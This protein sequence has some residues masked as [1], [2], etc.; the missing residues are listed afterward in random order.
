MDKK[1]STQWQTLL[2]EQF[3]EVDDRF[4]A[5]FRAPGSNNRFA[6]WNPFEPST[7][8][9]KSLLFVTAARQS[10]RFFDAYRRLANRGL[11]DPLTVRCRGCEIDADYL[12]AVEEWEFLYDAGVLDKAQTVVEI[13]AGF[14]RTCHTLLTLAPAIRR[15]LIID[16]EPMLRLSRAY[17]RRVVPNAEVTFIA[18]DDNVEIAKIAELRPDLV[19]NIDS[20]QEMLP[21]VVD[22]YMTGV[23]RHGSHFYCKNPIGKYPPAAVGLSD[24]GGDVLRDVFSLGLCRDVIDIFDDGALQAARETFVRAY[25]PPPASTGTQFRLT[26]SKVMELF[27]YFQHALYT[28]QASSASYGV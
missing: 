22:A 10:P 23:V 9:F 16:L 5:T 20:F 25:R 19:I 2:R 7:R 15:Y 1:V 21:Q 18:H 8:Y 13:G 6:A 24:P 27:P 14:G 28:H 12:A 4:L 3:L 26:A 11:G 17:L